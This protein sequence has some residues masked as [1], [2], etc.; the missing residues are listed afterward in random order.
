VARGNANAP[1]PPQP[2]AELE[3]RQPRTVSDELLAIARTAP[4][5]RG[6][7]ASRRHI[8]ATIRGK[9]LPVGRADA[10]TIKD[11]LQAELDKALASAP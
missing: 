10:E 2:S 3:D 11:V 1:E 4:L 5:G 8:E 9:G 7:R 6:G